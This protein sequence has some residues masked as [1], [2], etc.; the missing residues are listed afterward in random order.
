MNDN[1]VA[2]PRLAAEDE[3]WT[4]TRVPLHLDEGFNTLRL[5]PRSVRSPLDIDYVELIPAN[6]SGVNATLSERWGKES[7]DISFSATSASG[8]VTF[9]ADEAG[10]IAIYDLAGCPQ[11]YLDYPKQRSCDMASQP[12]GFYVARFFSKSDGRSCSLVISL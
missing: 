1:V 4:E 6:G 3:R 11:A 10:Q 8:I 12:R 9:E 7:P 5:A 2:E